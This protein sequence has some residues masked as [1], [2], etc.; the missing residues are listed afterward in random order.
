MKKIAINGERTHSKAS[1]KYVDVIFSYD[2]QTIWN[3]SIPIEYR[4]LKY[5]IYIEY[6]DI[7]STKYQVLF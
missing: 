1:E 6:C 5:L 4:R 7:S 3:G 2:D